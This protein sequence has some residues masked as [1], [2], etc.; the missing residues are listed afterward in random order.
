MGAHGSESRSAELAPERRRQ[1][2]LV[3]FHEHE[4]GGA[5]RAVL[6]VVPYL[7]A[8]GWE[9]AFWV[10]GPGALAGELEDRGYAV[11]GAPRMLR[12]SLDALREPPGPV[13]RVASVP[14]Y[15]R[16]LRAWANSV[17]PEIVHAN[18]RLTI[19]EA[20]A[21]RG[22][23]RATVLNV[24]ETFHTGP[25]AF[26][27]A[28]LIRIA[29]DAVVAPS[30]ATAQRLERL[31][32]STRVVPYGVEL[33]APRQARSG[34]GPLVVGTLA[35]VSRRKGTDT[36]LDA[37]REMRGMGVADGV[38]FRVVGPPASGP[39][40]AWARE[41]LATAVGEGVVHRE[42]ADPF[43]ELREWDVFAL[44][45]REDPFPLA[46]LEALATGLPVIGA[47]VDGIVEQ[48]DRGAAGILIPPDDPGSLARAVASLIASPER[49]AEL[50]AAGRRRVERELSFERQA[51]GIDLAYRAAVAARR[52]GAARPAALLDR[53][54]G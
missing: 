31:G 38:E 46:V 35:T 43:A 2:A 3:V 16:S 49:R 11:A 41:L 30:A 40:A 22:R 7:E 34:D 8:L 50:G 9:F 32:V 48:L 23:D 12:Y 29:V 54:A 28:Q 47:R 1:K 14:G 20:L 36:F 24:H 53:N 6:R 26:A 15:L 10:P 45:A 51:E 18:T 33:P 4:A 52:R 37:V 25:R 21:V 5:T 17:D 19:P 44:P 39:E 42:V 13:R 27:A